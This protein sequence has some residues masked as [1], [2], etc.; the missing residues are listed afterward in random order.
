MRAEMP[1]ISPVGFPW[2]ETDMSD[3]FMDP[4]K[5]TGKGRQ[6]ESRWQHPEHI[7]DAQGFF[8]KSLQNPAYGAW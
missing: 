8:M 3:S 7:N 4:E 6:I 2:W 5:D 1:R